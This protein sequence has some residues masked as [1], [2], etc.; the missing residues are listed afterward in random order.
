[1]ENTY[2]IE[3][4]LVIKPSQF[5]ITDDSGLY[6]TLKYI[7]QYTCY[8]KKKIAKKFICGGALF[9][10]KQREPFLCMDKRA[11]ICCLL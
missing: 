6:N 7:F 8:S 4:I 9:F 10:D 2:S 1:M 5:G 3:A 11:L